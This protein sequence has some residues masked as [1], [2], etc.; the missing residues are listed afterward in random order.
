MEVAIRLDWV[1]RYHARVGVLDAKAVRQLFEQHGPM[2][3]RRALRIL[4]NAADAEEALQ[5]VF[6][7]VM[8]GAESFES[9]SEITTWLYRITTNY[10]L[11]AVRDHK[12]RRELLEQNYAPDQGERA[13]SPDQLAILRS[14]LVDCDEREAQAAIYVFVDGMSHQEA[15][16]VLGVSRRT[17][18]NLIERFESWAK[19][20]FPSSE[21]P[22]AQ[23]PSNDQLPTRAGGQR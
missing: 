15:A 10:C 3:Y 20:R 9:R 1:P 23:E 16:E 13:A 5:E 8:R 6:I 18:G 19:Q 11:N 21:P 4:G 2:V 7:R 14:M 22:P 17:V 12:R